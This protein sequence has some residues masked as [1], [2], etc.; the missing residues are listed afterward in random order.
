MLYSIGTEQVGWLGSIQPSRSSSVASESWWKYPLAVISDDEVIGSSDKIKSL[1]GRGDMK[2]LPTVDLAEGDLPACH[3]R[4]EEHAGSFGAGQQA[5]RFDAPLEFLMQTLDGVAGPDGLPLL[6]WE[7]EESEKLV[8]GLL[9]AVGDG[10]ALETPFADERL[11][12]GL[13]LLRRLGVDHVGVIGADLVIELLRRMSQ[14]VPI[15]VELMPT[16]A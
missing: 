14:K 8:A 15:L 6:L 13:H 1:L 16:S 5:L 11:A 2:G 3:Q 4:P 10:A 9:E 12:P 7:A